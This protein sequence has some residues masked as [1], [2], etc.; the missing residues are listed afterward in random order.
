M[1]SFGGATDPR[2]TRVPGVSRMMWLDHDPPYSSFNQAL[3]TVRPAAVIPSS[4]P[5]RRLVALMPWLTGL[6][7]RAR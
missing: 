4:T 3:A 1:V 7:S 5:L 6:N 2:G